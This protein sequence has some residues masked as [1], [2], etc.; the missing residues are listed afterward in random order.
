MTDLQKNDGAG[1]GP[2]VYLTVDV[3]P[4]CP[5]YLWTWRGIVE[6]MPALMEVLDREQVPVTFFTTGATA[7]AHP[8]CIR[9]I[10]DRGHELACHGYSHNSFREMDEAQARGE[11]CQ[12]NAILR[13]FA[14]VTS[15]RAPYLSFQE[16]FLPIL[17]EEGITV[18]A[19]RALYKR[20][21]PVART[22]GGPARL[23][24]SVTS[25]V[26]RLPEMIRNPWLGMLKSPVTLFVHPWE[27]VDLTSERLRYDCRFRTGAPALAALRSTIGFFKDRGANFR[28]V[29]D[30]A[31]A[32]GQVAPA[33]PR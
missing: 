8:D 31:P 13:A 1:G 11:I 24:A 12:T 25:S 3:E 23:P 16:R 17:V 2:D 10:V 14:P 27:F 20:Q 33:S 32:S 19:S 22:S 29:R 26:L 6:G 30:Y 7:Q 9:S 5:P 4:D 21:E 15:F 28:L 18:D